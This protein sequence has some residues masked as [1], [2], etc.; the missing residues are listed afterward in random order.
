[1]IQRIAGLQSLVEAEVDVCFSLRFG[2]VRKTVASALREVSNK[3]VAA[4]LR[5][6]YKAE[7]LVAV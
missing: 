1:V 5:N 4:W 7:R 6:T 2:L 3:Q